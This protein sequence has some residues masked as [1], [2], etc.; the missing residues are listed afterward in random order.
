MVCF[1]RP[2]H[3]KFF[4]GLLR[5][6]SKTAD[7]VRILYARVLSLQPF[8]DGGPCHMET[9][10]LICRANQWASFCMIEPLSLKSL[11]IMINL[12]D[13]INLYDKS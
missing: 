9:S 10:P 12:L 7:I 1:G 3:L 11:T 5:K 2:Y 6:I 4:K 8:H 13:M